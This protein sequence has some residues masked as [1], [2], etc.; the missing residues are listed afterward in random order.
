[1][2]KTFFDTLSPQEKQRIWERT[3]TLADVLDNWARQ[4]TA[5][6]ATRIPTAALVTALVLPRMPLSDSLLIA[7]TILWIFGVDDKTDERTLTLVEIHRKAEQWCS[8]AAD[9]PGAEM[10]DDELTLILLDLR[11][12]LAKCCLFEP[13]REYWASRLR[14]LVETMAQEYQYGLRYHADGPQAL[15]S[16][17]EYLRV[18]THS[19][20]VPFW[21]STALILLKDSSVI[22][23]FEPITQVIEY[24]GAAIR[25]YNDIR[26]FDK[27]IREGGI[28][29]ILIKYHLLLGRHPSVP[30]EAIWAEAKQYV[31]QLADSYA[32]R[33]Y[34]WVRQ[35]KTDSQQF[36]EI[37]ARIVAF[38]AYFY[39]HSQHDYHLASLPD[40]YE[41]LETV[42]PETS[43]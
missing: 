30:E 39:G 17:D 3:E 35:Y 27:E 16:L 32:Q 38:H 42:Y 34:D 26:S 19:I 37:V 41:C 18:G 31:L 22:E 7:Q 15:P 33:C 40:A 25:L 21:K 14:L 2:T 28:N 12:E 24:A 5:I 20:G 13:L 29:S 11:R 23:H 36:E 6:R 4:Y 1:M 43:G 9:G 10:D 8:I